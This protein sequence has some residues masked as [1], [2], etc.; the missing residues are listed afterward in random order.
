[1]ND[2]ETNTYGAL[3]II[4]AMLIGFIWALLSYL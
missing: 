4:I 1:M 3:L 2:H